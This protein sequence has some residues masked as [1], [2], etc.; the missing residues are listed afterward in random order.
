MDQSPQHENDLQQAL[1][2]AV[3]LFDALQIS[4]ALI[5][6]L[7]AMV[8]GKSRFTEDVDFVAHP[9]HMQ[10]LKSNAQ[11]MQKFDFDP[12]CTWK[13]YHQSGIDIDIWKDE[14]ASAIIEHAQPIKLAGKTIAV[15]RAEDLVAMKLR[16]DRP[17]DEYDISEILKAGTIDQDQLLS[18]I[19]DGQAQRFEQIKK[20]IGLAE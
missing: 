14:H 13:L 8:Y 18:L 19:T 9:G 6:G 5:G 7:A 16:S 10:T 4:Y 20:R 2:A 3:G 15:A 1:L 11:V 12:E 17:Q